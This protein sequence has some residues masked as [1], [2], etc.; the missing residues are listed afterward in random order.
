MKYCNYNRFIRIKIYILFS[1]LCLKMFGSITGRVITQDGA[2]LAYVSVFYKGTNL[3]VVSSPDG[4][5]VLAKAPQYD[6][7]MVS[8]VGFEDQFFCA[9]DLLSPLEVVMDAKVYQLESFEVKSYTKH[10]REKLTLVS[11]DIPSDK[12]CTNNMYMGSKV[13]Q[14]FTLMEI[15]RIKYLKYYTR[16]VCDNNKLLIRI[17]SCND[18]GEPDLDLCNPIIVINKKESWHR[19]K[20]KDIE[21]FLSGDFFIVFESLSNTDDCFKSGNK[22]IFHYNVSLKGAYPHNDTYN[23]SFANPWVLQSDSVKGYKGQRFKTFSPYV[24]LG[25]E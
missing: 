12:I 7:I 21:L 9:K 4:K 22:P 16:K 5:F 19:I 11:G 15:K 1:V 10:K 14:K 8:C 2:P 18:N 3:G 25:F 13:A 6:T 20:L 23:T 17:M 24:E